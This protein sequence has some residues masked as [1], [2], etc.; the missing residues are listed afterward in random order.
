MLNPFLVSFFSL[1]SSRSQWT[2]LCALQAPCWSV[3]KPAC[4]NLLGFWC[5]P[6]GIASFTMSTSFLPCWPC[7][8]ACLTPKSEHSD[9]PALCLVSTE[10]Q[11]SHKNR[12]SIHTQTNFTRKV[13]FMTLLYFLNWGE[14]LQPNR[15]WRYQRVSS[16]FS[17]G[18]TNCFIQLTS[19]L[20][21]REVLLFVSECA[22]P[23]SPAFVVSYCCPSKPQLIHNVIR[24]DII[25]QYLPTCACQKKKLIT[26]LDKVKTITCFLL[27]STY[28]GLLA[29]KL[30]TGL[31]KAAMIVSVQLQTTQRQYD[32]ENSKEAHD[33]APDRLEE[34]QA[35]IS[36]VTHTHTLTRVQTHRHF[37]KVSTKVRTSRSDVTS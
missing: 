18:R 16:C 17:G 30:M 10:V 36:E 28:F 21:A 32:M 13:F 22:P 7:S 11:Y 34:L 15:C 23:V 31:A 25:G 3:S 8:P 6:V 24:Q 33:R 20:V 37:H 12:E 5:T 9:T 14:N 1:S 2:T 4:A 26:C 29:M 27:G 19:V 35:T